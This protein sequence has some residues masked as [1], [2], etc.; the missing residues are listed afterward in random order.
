MEEKIQINIVT[1][2]AKAIEGETDFVVCKLDE[3]E[4]GFLINH[5]PLIGKISDGFIRFNDTYVAISNGIVDFN[6]NVLTCFCQNAKTGATYDEALN[7]LRKEQEEILK[8][9]KRKLVDFTEAERNLALALKEAKLGG[10]S[11]LWQQY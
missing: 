7:N 4:Y 8:E 5:S 3:G 1:P 6:E 11:K 2:N 10:F 9:S